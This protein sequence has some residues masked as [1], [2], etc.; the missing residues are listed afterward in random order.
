MWKFIEFSRL[1]NCQKSSIF[2]AYKT[3]VFAA[4][5]INFLRHVKIE[6]LRFS[7]SQMIFAR[8]E[9]FHGCGTVKNRRFLTHRKMLCIFLLLCSANIKKCMACKHCQNSM[10]FGASKIKNF[11]MLRVCCYKI[12]VSK[13]SICTPNTKPTKNEVFCGVKIIDFD[14]VWEIL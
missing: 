8:I 14:S 9:N 10:N 7:N 13:S 11:R 12:V 6:N 2:D 1:R 3:F 4:E 5:E